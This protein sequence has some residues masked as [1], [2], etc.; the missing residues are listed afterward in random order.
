MDDTVFPPP[1]GTVMLKS[2]TLYDGFQDRIEFRTR[3]RLPEDRRR[4]LSH[5]DKAIAEAFAKADHEL[6][7]GLSEQKEQARQE[8]NDLYASWENFLN[9]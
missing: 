3:G 9:S 1:V 4:M 2:P 8:L 6:G 7:F 5:L